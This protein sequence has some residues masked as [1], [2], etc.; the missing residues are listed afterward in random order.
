VLS[1]WTTDRIIEGFAQTLAEHQRPF[2]RLLPEILDIHF[3]GQFGDASAQP[4]GSLDVDGFVRRSLWVCE[5]CLKLDDAPGATRVELT[6][7]AGLY[8]WLGETEQL[9]PSRAERLASELSAA[10]LALAV[11]EVDREVDSRPN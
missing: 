6:A 3:R 5:E 2:V 10:A 9:E 4:L 8:R 7:L 11:A 1:R